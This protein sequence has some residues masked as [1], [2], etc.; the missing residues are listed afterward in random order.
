MTVG[1]IQEQVFLVFSIFPHPHEE[2]FCASNIYIISLV[3][4]TLPFFHKKVFCASNIY[5]IFLTTCEVMY[6][7]SSWIKTLVL[8]KKKKKKNCQK[9]GR[10]KNYCQVVFM[11]KCFSFFVVFPVLPFFYE[12]ISCIYVSPLSYIVVE[13][14]RYE[15]NDIYVRCTHKKIIVPHEKSQKNL[16]TMRM[17][18]PLLWYWRFL[19]LLN[20]LWIF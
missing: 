17:N 14:T 19:D 11:N 20:A 10:K 1:C 16:L 18:S 3:F 9:R 2:V 5:I 15:K 13:F 12:K 7:L 8:T 4:P 6:L